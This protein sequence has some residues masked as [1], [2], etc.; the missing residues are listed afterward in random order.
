MLTIIDLG[1]SNIGSLTAALSLVGANFKVTN[2]KESISEASSLILPGVGTFKDGMASLN[3]KNLTSLIK[4][5]VFD[6]VPILGICLG[7]QLLA[8]TSEE[9][10]M[11]K[12]LGLISAEVKKLP[13]NKNLR[14]PN[15]GWCDINFQSNQKIFDGINQGDSFYFIHSYRLICKDN[16]NTIATIKFGDDLITVCVKKH[17][18][19]GCQF[20]P[21]KSQDKGLKLLANFIRKFD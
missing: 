10:G 1:I 11:H 20:H 21:E 15:V 16:N 4:N 3:E 19:Y 6:G 12:G 18:I 2:N 8:E 9:F 5:K 7:M 14:I 13:V 17:N